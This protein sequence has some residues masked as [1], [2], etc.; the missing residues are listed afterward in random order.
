LLPH[1]GESCR[2][3]FERMWNQSLAAPVKY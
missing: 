3:H 1:V 2:A